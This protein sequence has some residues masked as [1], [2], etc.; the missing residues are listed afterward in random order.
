MS[1]PIGFP[2]TTNVEH[3]VILRAPTSSIYADRIQKAVEGSLGLTHS[4]ERNIEDGL[5]VVEIC[6]VQDGYVLRLVHNSLIEDAVSLK[7]KSLD[8][9]IDVAE[10]WWRRSHNRREIIIRKSLFNAHMSQ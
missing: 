5:E 8:T 1:T 2:T 7:A 4:Q 9:A 6:Q 3:F 10:D